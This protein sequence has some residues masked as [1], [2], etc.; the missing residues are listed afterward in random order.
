MVTDFLKRAHV[1]VF[2]GTPLRFDDI[3]GHDEAAR[4]VATKR[5][6]SA[7]TAL[8]DRYETNPERRISAKDAAIQ[9]AAKTS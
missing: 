3:K 2:C 8:R 4:E 5:I 9:A 7:I 6:M 1:T